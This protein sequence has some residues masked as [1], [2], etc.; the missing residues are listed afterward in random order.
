MLSDSY[1]HLK[2]GFWHM[3]VFN[4]TE[5][6][7]DNISQY[8]MPDMETVLNRFGIEHDLSQTIDL[9]DTDNNITID[10]DEINDDRVTYTN[11]IHDTDEQFISQR[12]KTLSRPCKNKQN[13][14]ENGQNIPKKGQNNHKSGQ[15]KQK[16]T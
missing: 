9:I 4:S 1:K 8:S 14:T 13:N 10:I 7:T 2:N 5:A 16:R 3:S 11:N 12:I 15:N 6:N